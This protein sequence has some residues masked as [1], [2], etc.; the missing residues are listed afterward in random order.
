LELP[1]GGGNLPGYADVSPSGVAALK[2]ALADKYDQNRPWR[3]LTEEQLSSMKGKDLVAL[4]GKINTTD[5][6]KPRLKK[7]GTV[8]ARRIS[9]WD[10]IQRSDTAA[11]DGGGEAWYHDDSV[12]DAAAVEATLQFTTAS[13]HEGNGNA[14]ENHVPA[15]IKLVSSIFSKDP[16]TG[17]FACMMQFQDKWLES[18]QV[19]TFRK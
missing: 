11:T 4:I 1:F 17:I 16:S 14:H 10:Y 5:N 9:V 13:T 19:I 2:V 8:A 18:V 15:G 6:P 3:R 12:A 7:G